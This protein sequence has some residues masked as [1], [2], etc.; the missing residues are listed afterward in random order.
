MPP[1]PPPQKKKERRGEGG[2][3][4][5]WKGGDFCVC[6]EDNKLGGFLKRGIMSVVTM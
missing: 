2:G 1:P 4:V 5:W 3:C 6:H